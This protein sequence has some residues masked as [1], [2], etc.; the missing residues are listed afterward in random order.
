MAMT[1][2]GRRCRLHFIAGYAALITTIVTTLLAM[3]PVSPHAPAQPP[4]RIIALA[5]STAETICALGTADRLV[6]IG[7]YVTHPPSILRLPRVGGLYDPNLEAILALHPDLVILRGSSAPLEQLCTDHHIRIYRDRTD[8][9]SSIFGTIT[10]IGTLLGVADQADSL[11]ADLRA[12]LERIEQ[13]GQ[14]QPRPRVLLTLRSP[15]RLGA[16]TTVAGD[17]YLND[18]IRI[19][20]GDNIFADMQVPYPQVRLEEILTR[21]PDIIIEVMP[22]ESI[23]ADRRR[24]LMDQWRG[25]GSINAVRQNHVFFITDDFALI[26]SPRVALMAERLARIISSVRPSP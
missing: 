16:L 20:G 17:A 21:Q 19:A 14:G 10:D 7:S 5:P 12:A 6:G 3:G 22:G 25:L 13:R 9:L 11:T 18:L 4:Q 8:S 2:T 26:P 24:V 15:A 1:I 23:D